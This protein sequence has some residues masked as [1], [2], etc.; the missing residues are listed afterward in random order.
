MPDISQA[1]LSAISFIEGFTAVILL[2]LYGLL[3]K[4]FRERYFRFW[5][6]GWF[7][8][9]GF[10]SVRAGESLWAGRPLILAA[11]LLSLSAAFCFLVTSLEFG[12]KIRRT[13]LIWPAAALCLGGISAEYFLVKQGGAFLWTSAALECIIYVVAGWVF[14]RSERRRQNIGITLLGAALLLR[15]LHGIDRVYWSTQAFSLLRFSFNGLLEMAIGIAMAVLVLEDERLRSRVLNDKLHRLMVITASAA[16]SFQVEALLGEVLHH[17]MECLCASHGSVHLVEGGGTRA[18]FDIRAA[19]GFRP[20]FLQKHGRIAV[21]DSS[22]TQLCHQ[23]IPFVVTSAAADPLFGR[24]LEIEKLAAMVVTRVPGKEAPL[25]L[26]TLGFSSPREIQPDELNFLVNVSNLLGITIQNVWLF[27]KVS[28]TQRQWEFTFD[29]IEDLILVHDPAGV[30]LRV[31]QALASRLSTWPD[32]LA[33][34]PVREVFEPNGATWTRCPYCE[35]V[36][37]EAGTRDPNFDGYFLVT[38][39]DFHDNAGIHLG[40]VHVLKDFTDQME[41]ETKFRR[42][43]ENVQEGVF[44][45]TPDGR[46][47]DFNEAFMNLLGFE[48]RADLLIEGN[49][50]DY[51]ADPQDREKLTR[52]LRDHGEATNFE[53]RLKRRDGEI[54][55]VTESSSATRDAKGEIVAYQGFVL[56]I[57]ERKQAEQELRRRNRELMALNSLAQV[58]GESLELRE[59]LHGVLRRVC[60]LFDADLGGMYFLDEKKGKL[61]R[62]ASVG[63][64]SE[65]A[66]HFPETKIP[67]ELLQQ[68]Q[69]SRATVLSPLS[70]PLPD[71]FQDMQL[72]EGVEAAHWVVLWSK[73]RMLGAMLVACRRLKEFS[74]AELNLLVAI[75]NQVATAIDKSMLLEE[76]RRAYENLRR[77]QEQLLQSEK[78]A[79]VG[80]LISGVA[81]ELNNPLTAILG[82]SQLLTSE[83]VTAAQ[84]AGYIEKLYKQAQRT[85]RIVQNLLSFARQSKPERAPVQLNQIIEDTLAL[86]EYELRLNN[87]RIHRNFDKNLPPTAGDAHQLQQVFLNIL[88][89]ACDACLEKGNGGDIWVETSLQKNGLRVEF[90]DSGPGVTDPLR[91]FDPFYTTKPVGKGTGLGLSICY[92]IVKEHGGEI[93]VRNCPPNGAT[94]ELML[95]LFTT[96]PATQAEHATVSEGPLCGK[97][98]LVDDESSVLELEREILQGRCQEIRCAHSGKEAIELLLAESFDAIVTDAKMPG[99]IPGHALYRWIEMHR[100]SLACRVVFASSNLREEGTQELLTGT[101]NPVVEKPFRLDQFLAAIHKAVSGPVVAS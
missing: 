58:L 79:A 68:I 69:N 52:L 64:R 70:M 85:H 83:E 62:A 42:L 39:S 71:V 63:H 35:G 19:V 66:Q 14:W 72:K 21:N 40:T 20:E 92:G 3:A 13:F 101:G 81:H 90:T 89:N 18:A 15:G 26:L 78:M 98:L 53:F 65:Y 73:G 45:S 67:Q 32:S 60:E 9:S 37:K 43:F 24:W 96:L 4:G 51:Y 50:K 10:C 61:E 59:A 55:I 16:Q 33:G 48:S 41:A 86:R 46:F 47:V 29:S 99:E 93:G 82:Y 38:D 25:G 56:D 17:L 76:T 97:I 100:P 8:F 6:A 54:R 57:S 77:T 27:E 87:I 74:A 1:G 91:V 28:N 95:P 11:A 2:A 49:A 44:V 94:F 84:G 5:I 23:T 36:G 30:V 7:L 12:K 31:N 80:Q 88:N 75:G 34:R 22:V